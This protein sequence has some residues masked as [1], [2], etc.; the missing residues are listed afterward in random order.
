MFSVLFVVLA[1]FSLTESGGNKCNKKV[2]SYANCLKKGY[3]S[4]L[5][6]A[7]TKMRP[8]KKVTKKCKRIEKSVKKC[9]S[10]CSKPPTK[11]ETKPLPK[12]KPQPKPKPETK[13]LPKPKP[14]PKP[15]TKPLPKPKPET[16]PLPKPKPQPKPK[17][18]TKPLPKP[19]PQP[20]TKPLPKPKPE[21]KP[22]PKPEPKPEP[23]P[24][25]NLAC[26]KVGFDFWGADIRN[27]KSAGFDD[28]AKACKNEAGC[29]SFTLRNSDNNCWLKN[30]KSGAKGPS[31]NAAL[32]SMNM[33]CDLSSVDAS[34]KRDNFD[35]WGADLNNFKSN[36]FYDC[37]KLCRDTEDCQSFTLR[38]SDNYC[39]LKHKRGGQSGPSPNNALISMN[40]DC[41]VKVKALDKT[42]AMDNYDFWGA[43]LR[44]FKSTGFEQC[45]I[46]CGDAADCKSFTLRKSDNYCWLKTKYGG[47]V[48][49]SPNNALI[50]R[51]MKCDTSALDLSCARDGKDFWGADLRNFKSTSLK[52]CARVCRMAEDCQSLT[53]RKSDNYCWLKKKRGG[54][55]GPSPNAALISM[56]IDC[57]QKFDASNRACVK[58]NFDF[59]GADL[60]NFK[61][62]GYEDCNQSC[63]DAADCKSFTL[64]KSDNYCWLKTKAGGQNGPSANAALLSR[65]MSC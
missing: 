12:P 54:Q 55:S 65:N 40:I 14:K 3:P 34:C 57:S 52:E 36:G 6:C 56:N 43:D 51:N 30:K 35:F 13:P 16:K 1:V 61:S 49:P 60:R 23:K 17:P 25:V 29:K 41:S 22:L 27:F 28:C 11:P 24:L 46:A 63:F 53:L 26:K 21:T 7:S 42:C 15:E 5:G 32:T 38:K 39:W 20:E 58:D 19:K 50:S 44:N 4:T 33:D 62:A 2:K 37:A 31:T 10:P 45:A 8:S 59:W 47:A 64:K 9:D 18:E 48:G